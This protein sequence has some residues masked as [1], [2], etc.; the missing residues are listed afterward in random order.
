MEQHINRCRAL[1]R[2]ISVNIPEDELVAIFLN[3]LPRKDQAIIAASDPKTLEETFERALKY[4][5]YTN[6]ETA[7]VVSYHTATTETSRRNIECFNCGKRGHIA[8]DCFVASNQSDQ[9]PHQQRI[10]NKWRRNENSEEE[11]KHIDPRK[12]RQMGNKY[13][14][15][16]SER[17]RNH[18][19]NKHWPENKRY[20][21]W[22]DRRA[23]NQRVNKW[24][25]NNARVNQ[26]T[27]LDR[28]DC[29]ESEYRNESRYPKEDFH[30]SSCQ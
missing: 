9:Q 24:S 18:Q 10:G 8:R 12:E 22:S 27:A 20:A 5:T 3:T 17:R 29:S 11:T 16:V 15:D 26:A 25:N 30:S 19:G 28:E 1:R 7:R 23:N 14:L 2:G 4:A 21:D 6:D 13:D